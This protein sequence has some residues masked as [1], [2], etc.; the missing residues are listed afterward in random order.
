MI[1]DGEHAEAPDHGITMAPRGCHLGDSYLH[2][3]SRWS[4]PTGHRSPQVTIYR[5]RTLQEGGLFWTPKLV[6]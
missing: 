6:V 3:A 4:C 2:P 5:A 1:R